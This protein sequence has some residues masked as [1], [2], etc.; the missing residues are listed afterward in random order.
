MDVYEKIIFN[1]VPDEDG[2]PSVSTEAIWGI[3]VGLGEYRIDNV[4]GYI[5]GVSKGDVV[6]TEKID[7]E[8]VATSVLR[9]GG[10]TTL[11]VFAE[12]KEL[13]AKVVKEIEALGGR[14]SVSSAFSLFSVDLPPEVN[15]QAVDAYL[16]G[17]VE[18][19]AIAYED[20]CLQHPGIDS[21]RLLEV[22]SLATLGTRH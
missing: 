11:R 3:R 4:P 19:G 8:S 16:E 10:H 14:C 15:F 1:L 13:K 22:M 21:Q 20:A 17:L 18:S 9:Q 5:Y 12:D 2:Y 7:G 6:K